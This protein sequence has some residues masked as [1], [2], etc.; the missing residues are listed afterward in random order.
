[1][2]IARSGSPRL[3]AT[4]AMS[5]AL[6]AC[7]A[8]T[9]RAD[10]GTVHRPAIGGTPLLSESQATPT[11]TAAAISRAG[12]QR[13]TAARG[14]VDRGRCLRCG[15]LRLPV[16][17]RRVGGRRRTVLPL[18][19]PMGCGAI[20]VPAIAPTL[21]RRRGGAGDPRRVSAGRAAVSP[22]G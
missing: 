6:P 18:R 14:D 11:R 19:A 8:V 4:S 15:G 13:W 22:A 12:H 10:P 7:S 16:V 1:M 21:G 9:V 2:T 20:L 3:R 5:A 17:L